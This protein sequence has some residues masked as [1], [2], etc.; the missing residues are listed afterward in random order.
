MRSA[1]ELYPLRYEKSLVLA[2]GF[3]EDRVPVACIAFEDF[4]VN[5]GIVTVLFAPAGLVGDARLGGFDT[6]CSYVLRSNLER[7]IT[8]DDVGLDFEVSLVVTFFRND[9]TESKQSE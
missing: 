9:F 4:K 8:I 2:C 1:I 6:L 7:P 5:V 3:S